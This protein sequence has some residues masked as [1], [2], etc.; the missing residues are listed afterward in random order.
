M[1]ILLRVAGDGLVALWVAAPGIDIV[2]RRK[3]TVT[4]PERFTLSGIAVDGRLVYSP[5]VAG[6]LSSG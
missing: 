6:V 3:G 1:N 5:A 2:V 4:P